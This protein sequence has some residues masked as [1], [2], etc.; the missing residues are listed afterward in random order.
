M[1]SS[2]QKVLLSLV[3]WA[4]EDSSPPRPQLP[5]HWLGHPTTCHLNAFMN[6]DTTSN[7]TSGLL[8]ASSTRWQHYSLRSMETR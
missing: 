1:S 3:T 2:Q 6:M 8:V 4:W 5:T 7:L